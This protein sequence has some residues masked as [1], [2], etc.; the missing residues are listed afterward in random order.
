[1]SSSYSARRGFGLSGLLLALATALSGQSIT[2]D[3]PANE[4][5]FP[6]EV[7]APE[8]VWRDSVNT[9]VA[10]QI[11]VASDPAASGQLARVRTK[12]GKLS[13]GEIDS[14]VVSDTNEPPKLT[15]AQA[16]AHTWRPESALWD[17][18]KKAPAATVTFTGLDAKGAPV[19]KAQLRIRTSSDPVGAPI[20]YRDVPLMPSPTEKGIIKPLAQTAIP[21]IN[22]SLRS[23]ADTRSKVVMTGIHTCA[24]CHSFSADGKTMGLDVDGPQNDKGLYALLP[25]KKQMEIKSENV[26]AWSTF[27]GKLGGKLRVG[28]MS[29]VSPDGRYVAT[30]I[31]ENSVE[32]SEYERRKTLTEVNTNYYVANFRDYRFLQVFYPTRGILAWYSRESG[33]LTPLPGA[34]DP[35]YVQTNAVWSPDGKYLVFARAEA[36]DPYAA[37][38]KVAEFANDPTE[39][40]IRYDLY[41]I[42]FNEGRGG[43]PEP[44]RGASANGFSNSFPK[45]SPDGKWIVFVKARNGLLMRPDSELWIVPAAG[46]EARKLAANTSRMNSWHSFSPNSR[47]LVFSSKSRSPYTEMFLTHIDD[48]GNASP[49]VLIENAKAANRAVNLP[50]FVNVAPGALENIDPVVTAYYEIS[51]KATDLMHAGR[52][53]EAI[54]EWRRALSESPDEALAHNNLGYCLAEMGRRVEAI[55]EYEEALK[56]SPDYPEALNNLGSALA[57]EGRLEDAIRRL[58]RAIELKPAYGSAH[59]NLGTTLARLNRVDEALV[60][61][62][63][64]VELAPNNADAHNNLGITLAAT[65]K[66]SESVAELESAVRLSGGGDG[67]MLDAL[68]QSYAHAGQFGKAAET[69]RA[70]LAWAEVNRQYRMVGDFRRKLESYTAGKV[71]ENN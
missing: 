53:Q 40:Q 22:W 59:S 44:V 29:Q 13:F 54:I 67:L 27:R 38:G 61:F 14:R 19:S 57:A 33:K 17:A 28:F 26:V 30:M 8:F 68:A 47:W 3:Y 50:E 24:N 9:A 48:D 63:K 6:P 49:P 71:P 69:A 51:D 4:T 1:M 65:G 56:L 46:G 31:N 42:P 55:E 5:L 36:K 11:E 64:G 2:V 39:T 12:G 23:V 15:P 45:V 58:Q 21:L 35:R 41:R 52:M 10:W 34:D 60:H 43:A 37:G 25:V 20:F 66:W 7:P 70:A 16:A 32:Q 62:R 18:M